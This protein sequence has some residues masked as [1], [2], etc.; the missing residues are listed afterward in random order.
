M[1]KFLH[2]IGGEAEFSGEVRVTQR[3]KESL[4]KG[5]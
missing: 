3:R 2:K 1:K 4:T 5:N